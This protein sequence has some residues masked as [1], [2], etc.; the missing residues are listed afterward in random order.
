MEEGGGHDYQDSIGSP[1]H[2]LMVDDHA[3]FYGF[4]KTDLIGQ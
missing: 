1:G 4:S 3:G 2:P